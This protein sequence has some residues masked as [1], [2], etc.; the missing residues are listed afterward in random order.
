MHK[1]VEPAETNESES[2][3]EIF[4]DDLIVL[5]KYSLKE[6]IAFTDKAFEWFPERLDSNWRELTKESGSTR[7]KETIRAFKALYF[8]ICQG[9]EVEIA[10]QKIITDLRARRLSEEFISHFLRRLEERKKDIIKKAERTIDLQ[11]ESKNIDKATIWRVSDSYSNMKWRSDSSSR[12][13][14]IMS[15]MVGLAYDTEDC[16]LSKQ[17][18]RHLG[19]FVFASLEEEIRTRSPPEEVSHE[20]IFKGNLADEMGFSDFVKV[21]LRKYVELSSQLMDIDVDQDT[22]TL[23][24]NYTLFYW[25]KTRNILH[26][27]ESR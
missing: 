8:L 16:D 22:I 26:L 9:I 1:K 7:K 27:L 5:S 14:E 4:L 19:L 2:P 17:K 24:V 25:L 20:S 21:C 6:Q 15:K 18:L 3:Y 12:Y 10:H 23:F 13:P 11:P